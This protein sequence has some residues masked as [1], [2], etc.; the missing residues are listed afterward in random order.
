MKKLK[1][2]F[3]QVEA[4]LGHI[5]TCDAVAEVFKKK[6]GDKVEVLHFDFYKEGHGEALKKFGE[7]MKKTVYN[8]TSHQFIGRFTST[9]GEI[10]G[11]RIT[12]WFLMKLW[13]KGAFDECMTYMR[14]IDPDVVFSTHW[15]TNYY[16]EHMKEKKPFTVMYCPDAKLNASFRYRA[17]ITLLS[18]ES[19]VKR[20]KRNIF[21]NSK[22]LRLVPFCIRNS[23]FEL[24]STREE[25]REKLGIDKDKFTVLFTEGGYGNGKME[26]I[27]QVLLKEDLP[28]TVI[29]ICGKNE[30]LFNRLKQMRPEH[31][32]MTYIPVGFTDR[33]FD[34]INASNLFCGKS[35]NMIAEPTFFGVPSI[36]TSMSTEIEQY[37]AHYYVKYVK[38]AIIVKNPKKIVAKIRKFY[39]EPELMNFYI[40]KAVE[41]HKAYGAEYTADLLWEEINKRF[42]EYFK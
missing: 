40:Q 29:A 12:S 30:E 7:A 24:K 41:H 32:S 10:F 39:E 23:A 38:S 16:A 35:G 42:P 28:I 17:D 21:Y 33:I 11:S 18:M 27:L 1:V 34:Y 8:F 13:V 31:E 14:E 3:P 5:M 19:G 36:I 6:Y 22:N 4:G 26:K 37:I 15:A 9:A 20:A 25:S 2:F